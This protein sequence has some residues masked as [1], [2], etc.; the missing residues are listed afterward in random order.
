M[1][2]LSFRPC[3]LPFLFGLRQPVNTNFGLNKSKA[4]T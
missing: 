2:R 3:Q 1:K 4:M